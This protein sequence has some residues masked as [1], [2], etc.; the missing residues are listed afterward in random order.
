CVL[1]EELERYQIDLLNI[2]I[3]WHESL[4]PTLANVAPQAAFAS[5]AARVKQRFPHIQT[6]VSN[7]I[8]DLRHGEELLL[9]GVADVIA[10]GRPFLADRQIVHKAASQRFD[11]INPCIAC[12]QDCLDHMFL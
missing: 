8:N 9:D 4:V 1:I 12:N 3:G 5:A 10:M 7:R 2:S 11:E 6:C